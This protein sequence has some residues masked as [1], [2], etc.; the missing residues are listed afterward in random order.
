MPQILGPCLRQMKGAPPEETAAIRASH[1]E[2]CGI[3]SR[4]AVAK[5]DLDCLKGRF[6]RKCHPRSCLLMSRRWR[7][8]PHLGAVVA[9]GFLA[10]GGQL[11]WM[12]SLAQPG[13]ETKSMTGPRGRYL[14][15]TTVLRG[16]VQRSSIAWRS[17]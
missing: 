3:R 4:M 5:A 1:Q 14:A 11:L 6:Q 12:A 2:T 17:A 8:P 10:R 16:A 15:E 13:G 9:V 7:R